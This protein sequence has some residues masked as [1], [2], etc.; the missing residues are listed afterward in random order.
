MANWQA[1]VKAAPGSI[2]SEDDFKIHFLGRNSMLMKFALF[3]SMTMAS[4]VGLLISAAGPQNR[5]AASSCC[6]GCALCGE[7]C[8]CNCPAEC[9]CCSGGVCVC[10]DCVCQCCSVSA[11]LT[12][13]AS[14]KS[15]CSAK[16]QTAGNELKSIPWEPASA[17][18]DLLASASAA[19][20]KT[21][22]A[23]CCS[24]CEKCGE[25]C[26]CDCAAGCDCC[27]SGVCV[28]ETCHCVCC[29]E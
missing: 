25:T 10:E 28:C 5:L 9:D 27:K 22:A 2:P 1:I 15:C 17:E 18:R 13:T 26:V 6:A 14:T 19:Q 11:R 3:A 23:G 16:S 24:G 29:A 7:G 12:E 20:G 4:A 21:A 8:P